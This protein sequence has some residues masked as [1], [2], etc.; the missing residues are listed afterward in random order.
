MAKGGKKKGQKK[1]E[2]QEST[3]SAAPQTDE[4]TPS[5]SEA[6]VSEPPSTAEKI[7]TEA[8]KDSAEPI[9]EGVEGL[10]LDLGGKRRKP[11]KKKSAGQTQAGPAETAS[12][13]TTPSEIKATG[14]GQPIAEIT[15]EMPQPGPSGEGRG[16]G[17]GQG[18]PQ[19]QAGNF[20]PQR[21]LGHPGIFGPTT[22]SGR[23]QGSQDGQFAQWGR[24]QPTSSGP[25]TPMSPSE[26]QAFRG[27]G[28]APQPKYTPVS[29]VSQSTFGKRDLPE[30][31][32]V[33]QV[34]SQYKIPD[35]IR[36]ATVPSRAIRLLTNYLPMSIKYIKVHRYDVSFKPDRPKK[37]IPEAFLK[38]KSLQFKN[39]IIAF[40]QMKNC[41]SIQP[42]TGV[43]QT[44]RH[45]IEVELIDSNG[46]TVPIEVSFKYT[47]LVDLNRLGQHMT[48]GGSSL[49][50]PTEAIQCID[51]IL[52][53]GTLEAYVKAGKQFF[54]RPGNPIDLGFGLEMWTGLFQS[55]I[56]TSKAYINIDVA[57]KGFPKHQSMIQAFTNDFRLDPTRSLEQQRN[58][59]N[60]EL[61]HEYI[62]GLRVTA[63]IG[64]DTSVK[65]QRREFICNRVVDPPG[66]LQ[67][68]MTHPDGRAE[69]LS[70]LEYF[71]RDK[72]YRLKYP[73]LNCV[74]VG[75]ANKSLYF[76]MEL[77]EIVYGQPMKKQLNEFQLSKM[78]QEAATAPNIRKNKIEE[79]IKN[80]N[81]SANPFFKHF[82]LQISD[83]FL[84]VEA[85]V[86]QPPRL[87]V[88]DRKAVD[89]RRGVWNA[90][91]V[92]QPSA[93]RSWGFVAIEC[94][95]TQCNYQNIIQMVLR[96]GNQ[97]GM[98]VEQP[99]CIHFNIRMSDLA[100]VLFSALEKDINFLFVIVS[101]S[102]RDY[103]HRVKRFAELEVGIL[104][105]CIKEDTAARRMNDQ[106]VRN[107]LLKVNSKLMGINQALDGRCMP[108]CLRGP[109]MVVGADVTHP[110]PDQSNI[111]SIAA[112]TASIDPKCFLYNIELCVQTP[113]KEIIVE[114][115]DMMVDHLIV[116]RKHN[117]NMLPKKIYVFRDGVSEGQFEEVMNS[118]LTAVY[119]A[120]R[121]MTGHSEKPEV[122]FLLVQ[123]RHHTRFF[124][125]A[126]N[127]QN[128]EPG[129]VVDTQIVHA[130]ELD[131]YLVSHQAIKGTARPTRYHAVCNDGGI[132]ID[133]VEQLTYY[134]CHLYARCM[135]AV[136]YPTPTYYA[137]LA[138]LR[139]KSLTHGDKFDNE[140]LER[141]PKRLHVL[142]KMLDFSRMFFV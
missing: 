33:T 42:L 54:R 133:E 64:A 29:T 43:T 108:S 101:K 120:Y 24:P 65:G 103:Y 15:E 22:S 130:K 99:K 45:A 69:K 2:A 107:I 61:F 97:M 114:F 36:R 128:V 51:V 136:S 39:H 93:L 59:R 115:E 57:H 4:P 127:P 102:G 121:R 125:G 129:T 27:P 84:E 86:L 79:V 60:V 7:T 112:V 139:A 49:N 55:A 30:Q 8:P 58:P 91:T 74:W 34:V 66:R 52:R 13:Q 70:V 5:G 32:A 85:K 100:N 53:Q 111:P 141:H 124:S 131:F 47:G 14:L 26:G 20:P 82:G 119:R 109:V 138:C 105:Q 28:Q 92:L 23:G 98:Y 63:V 81:Y 19:Q 9:E 73:D 117:Q 46:K 116:Y 122:L 37:M 106:T 137:H 3:S 96:V 21:G 83:K 135:R 89:P 10:G 113:K 95:P 16:R 25:S 31:R 110:S 41:Y 68:N 75:P 48:T 56:F 123:K 67:F 11:R 18:W 44:E 118:E 90:T 88:G 40:D 35:A 80:M 38:A 50:P 62:R 76:P 6:Q 87:L 104:T 134:L 132:P 17:R 77:L 126:Q 71:R 140:A 12:A 78:V 142:K 94:N 1:E 72:K